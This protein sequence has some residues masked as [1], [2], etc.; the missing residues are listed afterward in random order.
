MKKSI[1][2]IKL[3]TT[4]EPK[5]VGGWGWTNGLNGDCSSWSEETL[6]G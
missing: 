5:E 3:S 1:P 4:E 2:L 6:E